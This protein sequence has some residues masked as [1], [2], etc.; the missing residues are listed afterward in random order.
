MPI[1]KRYKKLVDL[2][3]KNLMS[4]PAVTLPVTSSLNDVVEKMYRE[5]SVA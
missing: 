2:K 5:K 4:S 3:V 1:H